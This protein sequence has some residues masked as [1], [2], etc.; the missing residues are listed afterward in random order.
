[1]V[2][3]EIFYSIQ[4]ES[5][6]SGL[7]CIFIR[8]AGCNL[9]CDW[10]DTDYSLKDND[11][12][13]MSLD[14]ILRDIKKYD[15]NLVEITGGEPLKQ[16][17]TKLLATKLIQNGFEVLMETNGTY[18]LDGLGKVVK[19]VDIKCPSSGESGSFLMDNLK[20]L[21]PEDEVK[22]VIASRADFDF[23]SDFVLSNL[24]DDTKVVF[25]PVEGRMSLK[26]LA[27][28]ILSSSI[29]VRLQAQLHK[30]IWGSERGR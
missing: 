21:L 24:E 27:E 14:D 7:P 9:R 16:D 6:Y 12:T 8:T 5:T 20:Y 11:G 26:E 10:C 1:M 13:E 29:N 4:G 18:S 2:I 23:A 28:W 19:I 17:D 25:S 15:C 22:F 3:N 30:I